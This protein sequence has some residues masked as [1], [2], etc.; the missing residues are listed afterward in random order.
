ME[1]DN[2]KVVNVNCQISSSL[3][4]TPITKKDMSFLD[5]TPISKTSSPGWKTG[6]PTPMNEGTLSLNQEAF[7]LLAGFVSGSVRMVGEVQHLL[8]V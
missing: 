8:I 1:P 5:K 4:N 7:S 2:R 3:P 6:V